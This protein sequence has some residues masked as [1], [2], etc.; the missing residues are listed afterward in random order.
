VLGRAEDSEK[1]EQA[2][3]SVRLAIN[4]YLWSPSH[5]LYVDS[6]WEVG[7]DRFSPQTNILAVLF[8]IPDHY[9]KIAIC[10]QLLEPEWQDKIMTPYF[11][12]YFAEILCRTGFY[13]EALDVIRKRWGAMLQAGATTFWERFTP[14]YSLCHGW[15]TGPVRH[16]SAE[17]LGVRQVAGERKV[18]ITPQPADLRWAR[19]I[20]PTPYGDVEVD[21]RNDQRRFTMQVKIPEGMTAEVLPPNGRAVKIKMD[22]AWCEERVIQIA[23]GTHDLL[24]EFERPKRERAPRRPQAAEGQVEIL[25]RSVQI[26]GERPRRRRPPRR[27]EK[28]AE[29]LPSEDRPTAPAA[30]PPAEP[31]EPGT[32]DSAKPRSR[33]RR[34]SGR[35]KTSPVPQITEVESIPAEAAVD[36]SEAPAQPVVEKQSVLP[37]QA[38][39]EPAP[40]PG[41][42]G[43]RRRRTPR[44]PET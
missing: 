24:V 1:Y 41:R 22:G 31:Q 26:L 36:S 9:R 21:W 5:G 44:S 15:S 20:V 42:T 11:A 37:A 40:Q 19:G 32:E 33:G 28:P 16:L 30:P 29:A 38:E 13:Q 35:R 17:F 3:S 34:R 14:D 10:R 4:R 7:Y 43:R 27:K 23:E 2:A 8:D 39:G 12:S 25:P 6:R 18:R